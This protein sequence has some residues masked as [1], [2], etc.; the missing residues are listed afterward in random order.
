MQASKRDSGLARVIGTGGL[1]ASIFNMLVGAGI[2]VVPAQLS[3]SM[4]SLAPLA[5]LICAVGVAA[6]GVC[7]GESASRVPS[8]GGLYASVGE[9]FGPCAGYVAGMLFWVSN[10]MAAAAVSSALGAA[11]A[12]ALPASLQAPGRP[13]LIVSAVAA[14]C[15]TNTRGAARG[16]ELMG[17]SSLLKLIPL[18]VFLGVG[19][20]AIKSSHLTRPPALVAA[21]VGQALLLTLFA[22]QGFETALCASGEV[23]DPA[24]T[25]PRALFLGL[26]GVTLLYIAIQLV[27]QGVL[28]PALAGSKAP[29]ADAM[30]GIH[31]ALGLLILA[32]T[33]VSMFGWMTADLLNSPR[34]LFAF[35]RDG[36]LPRILGRTNREQVPAAA[37]WCYGVLVLALALSGTFAELAAPATLVLA[38]LYIAVCAAAWRLARAGIAR[39]GKPL[40][41]RWI[42]AAAVVGSASMMALIA[43]GSRAELLGLTAMIAISLTL[44][45]SQA[46]LRPD[47]M[48]RRQS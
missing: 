2:F 29:L 6:I 22:F 48:G 1:S 9:A 27:A 13:I 43:L 17:V 47:A 37:I 8:S 7:F 19:A 16:L 21:D 36:M 23:R 3:A 4:G 25:I 18:C 34:I 35:A 15:F 14:V 30:A 26:G 11:I 12:S 39:A 46:W 33:A 28:G 41:F 32:G 45:W 20:F 5:V 31:P 42:G 24:R 10:L 40:G 44:Y 38:A